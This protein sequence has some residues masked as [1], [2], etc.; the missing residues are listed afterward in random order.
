MIQKKNTRNAQKTWPSP[1]VANIAPP[2]V[3]IG[4]AHVETTSRHFRKG[5]IDFGALP[6][7]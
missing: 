1:K 6:G 4:T 5:A 3:V 7:P 2:L